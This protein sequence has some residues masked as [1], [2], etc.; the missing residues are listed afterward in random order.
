MYR[1]D[2]RVV[3]TL[4]AGGTNFMF[5]AIRGNE[6]LVSRNVERPRDKDQK[7][8]EYDLMQ[9]TEGFQ[10]VIR[11]LEEK[12]NA[13]PVAISFAFPGPADYPNGI[14]G[15]YLPNFPGWREG[16][17]LKAYLEG[18]F[19]LPVYINNDADLYA[20]GEAIAGML[21]EINSRLR[22]AGSSKQYKN[23][24]GYTWGTGF[25]YGFVADGKLHRGDN[26]CV[27]TFCLSHKHYRGIIVEDG[28]AERAIRRVYGGYI[29]DMN[30][31]F[32]PFAISLI[33]R[34]R[35]LEEIDDIIAASKEKK[36]EKCSTE[37]DAERY[38]SR[39]ARGEH[40][41]VLDA[42]AAKKAY[43]E[44]GEIAGD[45]MATA[46]TLIDGLIVIGGGIAGSRDLIMPSLLEEM[47]G[48][49]RTLTGDS[50]RR[51]QSNIYDLDN[52]EEFVQ[53]ATGQSRKIKVYGTDKEV[54]YDPEKRI[55][56]TT[57]KIGAN[58]A[59]SIGAYSFAL[60]NIDNK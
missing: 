11:E 38:L 55:G 15:G 19:D 24:I 60:A 22:A 39:R 47:R 42:E 34:G 36:G 51:V 32:D 30:H 27:E 1:S 2:E 5:G 41:G 33:A 40:V 10:F 20:Y 13:T 21:P 14:I 49:I 16:V 8:L 23:L 53:F 25:G 59:I 48:E 17:A 4:D 37:I 52:E 58:R 56:V 31:G 29:K 7:T 57:S 12:H 50:L 6:F 18:Q 9:I 43:V 26:S 46:A 54:V 3:V 35:S 28:A 45:A 44:F